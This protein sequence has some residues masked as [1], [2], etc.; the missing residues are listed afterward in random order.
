MKVVFTGC[1]EHQKRF[2][3]NTG[4]TDKLE[5]GKVYEVKEIEVHSWHTKYYLEGL[6]G[7]F[8]SVCF[9]QFTDE[10]IGEED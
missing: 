3:N 5:V 8:N 2:G 1:T 4:D 7:S 9:N 10:R 6:E